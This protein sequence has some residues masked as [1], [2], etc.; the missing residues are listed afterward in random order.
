MNTIDRKNRSLPFV[1]VTILSI[2]GYELSLE[3]GA[4]HFKSKREMTISERV[5]RK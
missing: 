4:G 1:T 3:P 5:N 2:S